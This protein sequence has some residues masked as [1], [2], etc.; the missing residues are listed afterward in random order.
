MFWHE[1][2]AVHEGARKKKKKK[3]IH[4]SKTEVLLDH[5]EVTTKYQQQC[6]SFYREDGGATAVRSC[7]VRTNAALG[8]SGLN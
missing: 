3:A 1:Q 4:L 5:Y 2:S 8:A 6:I 7:Q